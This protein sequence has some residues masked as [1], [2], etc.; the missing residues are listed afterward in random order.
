VLFG[1][2]QED[3]CVSGK[4]VRNPTILRV[5][6]TAWLSSWL[7]NWPTHCY[8]FGICCVSEC[9]PNLCVYEHI[10]ICMFGTLENDTTYIYLLGSLRG[11]VGNFMNV[12]VVPYSSWSYRLFLI[13]SVLY[14]RNEKFEDGQ[15]EHGLNGST[16]TKM[17]RL[18]IHLQKS[19]HTVV[20]PDP[21]IGLE[22]YICEREMASPTFRIWQVA[23]VAWSHCGWYTYMLTN[24]MDYRRALVEVGPPYFLCPPARLQYMCFENDMLT[25]YTRGYAVAQLL[26][27]FCCKPQGSGFDSWYGHWDFPL[28]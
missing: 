8:S 13:Y 27:T 16:W 25:G 7:E 6:V 17:K 23:R 18:V 22:H 24:R 9:V 14:E 2:L 26:E 12:S 15:F 19:V 1:D 10:Y 11:A 28:M 4:T 21:L 3:Y 5:W 20:R